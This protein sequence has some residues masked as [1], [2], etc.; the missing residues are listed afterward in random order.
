MRV[1][2]VDGA[3]KAE[4][5]RRSRRRSRIIATLVTVGVVAVVFLAIFIPLQLTSTN[6]FCTSCHAM[7]AAKASWQRSAHANVS[8]VKCHIPPGFSS[9]FKW[10]S[11]EWLNIW[12][13]WLNVKQTTMKQSP[14][15]NANCLSCHDISHIAIQQGTIRMPHELHVN[16]RG[17]NCIDCHDQ[18]S[19]AAASQSAIVSMTIC[20]MCHNK[21]GPAPSDCAFC[22]VTPPPKN[23][24]PP[25]YVKTH[26]LRA[27]E[28]QSECLRCHHDKAA[29]CDACHA[30]PTPAHFSDTWR[31]T[32]G[33]AAVAD[34]LGCLG[35]HD[36]QTFCMQCHRVSHP[37]DWVQ[38]HGPVATQ[39]GGS[40]L[41]CHPTTMCIAC[42]SRQTPPI[43]TGN[44][45]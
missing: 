39:S 3:G 6:S 11:H 13:S 40:C 37:A 18:V 26:G 31:Y 5:P 17:L 35:C 43:T 19:H 7:D 21:T 34:R 10:R 30:R 22:H 4:P 41:V 45:P 42:H 12:A 28:N 32:H 1:S 27:L 23:V 38:T 9:A 29:F 2:A 20:T 15:T 8:C 14:P 16:L 24:H 36:E 25:D 44:A 33:K